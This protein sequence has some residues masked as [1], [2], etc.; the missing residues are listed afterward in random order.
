VPPKIDDIESG[1]KAT[2]ACEWI[3]P[4]NP[5]AV[6]S[7]LTALELLTV[8]S[9]NPTEDSKC[10]LDALVAGD[11]ADK[12]LFVAAFGLAGFLDALAKANTLKMDKSRDEDKLFGSTEKLICKIFVSGSG[13]L[14]LVKINES[15]S[16]KDNNVALYQLLSAYPGWDDDGS[17]AAKQL[18]AKD[19]EK[20]RA[21][22]EMNAD[23]LASQIAAKIA[24][25]TH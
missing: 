8:G 14:K 19:L 3:D 22:F 18:Y 12:D 17:D 20:L 24:T 5:N 1:T 9:Q 6:R 15:F 4:N 21:A 11:P 10:A 16:R 2:L 25:A 23:R 7:V 13:K